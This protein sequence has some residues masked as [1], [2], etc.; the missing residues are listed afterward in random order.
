MKTWTWQGLG[1][2]TE[3]RGRRPAGGSEAPRPRAGGRAPRGT[4]R[5]CA[6]A[7]LVTV[8]L[9]TACSS[10]SSGPQVASLG[11][12]HGSGRGVG[13]LTQAQSDRDMLNFARC[14][15]AHGVN[16]PDPVH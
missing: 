5:A 14:M 13:T 10:A 2:V 1:P 12:H 4:A 6:T 16:V 3:E 11:G 8:A 9:A 15:R 7:A